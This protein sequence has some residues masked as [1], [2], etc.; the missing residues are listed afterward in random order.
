MLILEKISSIFPPPNFLR[1]PSAGVD[2]SDTSLKYIQFVPHHH[3]GKNLEL[4]F[5]GD[6]DIPE[7]V[8]S[9]GDVKDGQKL[10]EALK[11]VR[12]RTGIQYV[13]VSLPEERAYL[14][15]TEIS[16]NTPYKEIR[17]QLEFRLEENVPLSPR[18]AYFDYHVF[19]NAFDDN[20]VTVSVTVYARETIN[21]YYDACK[22]AGVTPLSFE[23]EAQAIARA[24]LPRG[25]KGTHLIVDFGKTRTGVGIVHRGILMYTSTIDIGGKELS[26]ALRRQLGDKPE[27]ELTDIK[28]NQGLVR[29]ADDVA[30]YEALVTTM[31]AIKDEIALRVEY[32]NN[33]DMDD[34]DRFIQSV[35][36]CG[37]S[38]NLKGLPEYLTETLG[39]ET[40]RASV[41]QNAFNLEDFVPPIGLRYS[42]GYATAIGLGLA[43]FIPS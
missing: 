35:I 19:D 8:L 21:A 32:W 34:K 16:K 13:R 12:T 18:D 5:W 6:I 7:G 20:K 23:V 29:G 31:S 2:V 27:H 24:S 10:A 42:Y 4:K 11:E 17:S 37:G 3:N 40:K 28:N 43:P 39:V 38:A 33:R 26:T 15:E 30:V 9:R 41:W 36:L 14:F 25:D 1:L 22:T